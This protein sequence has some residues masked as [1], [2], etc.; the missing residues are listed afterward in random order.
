MTKLRIALMPIALSTS[1]LRCGLSMLCSMSMYI[2]TSFAMLMV[3]RP[4]CDFTSIAMVC[5]CGSTTAAPRMGFPLTKD[6]S[7]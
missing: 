6:P 2:A 4:G 5:D 1:I 3:C 7:V